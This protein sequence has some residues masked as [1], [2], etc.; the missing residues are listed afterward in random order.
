[1]EKTPGEM[2]RILPDNEVFIANKFV[3][4]GEVLKCK[5]KV[6]FANAHKA[7]K[8]VFSRTKPSR[9]L[10]TLECT[11]TKWHIKACLWNIDVYREFLSTCSDRI[12]R[13]IISAYNCKSCNNHCSGGAE[14]TFEGQKYKKCIGCCFYFS[15]LCETDW[16]ALLLLIAKEYESTNPS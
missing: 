1:M 9:V 6:R 15:E 14:F 13:D 12:K 8:C 16:N 7:W 2:I 4:F 11:E 10:F 3:E 5:G